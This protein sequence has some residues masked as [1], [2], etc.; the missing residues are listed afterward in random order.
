MWLLFMIWLLLPYIRQFI[1]ERCVHKN[2]VVFLPNT[3]FN[4]N[5]SKRYQHILRAF[6]YEQKL[7]TKLDE[8][9][10]HQKHFPRIDPLVWPA[11]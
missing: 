4:T 5:Q 11:N 8:S 6:I 3:Y 10:K 2:D 9:S 1:S 7:H